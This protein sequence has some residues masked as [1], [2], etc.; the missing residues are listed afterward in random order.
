MTTMSAHLAL[1]KDDVRKIYRLRFHDKMAYKTIAA[2]FG[3]TERTVSEI[4]RGKTWAALWTEFVSNNKDGF[5]HLI[6]QGA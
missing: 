1:D 3:V 5:D 6:K 4:C 2:R